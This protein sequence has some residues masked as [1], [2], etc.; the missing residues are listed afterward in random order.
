MMGGN[1]SAD[2]LAE[3]TRCKRVRDVWA[4]LTGVDLDV[5]DVV[6]MLAAAAVVGALSTPDSQQMADEAAAAM[7]GVP[8]RMELAE[9]A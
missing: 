9:R 4:A 3:V 1:G 5:Q 7:S 6:V 2:N 8:I